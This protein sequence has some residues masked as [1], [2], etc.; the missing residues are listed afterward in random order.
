MG[1]VE[2]ADLENTMRASDACFVESVG[3]EEEKVGADVKDHAIL[4]LCISCV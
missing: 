3:E 4:S 1:D 2:D